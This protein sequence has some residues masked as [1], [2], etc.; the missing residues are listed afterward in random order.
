MKIYL[1]SFYRL[2]ISGLGPNFKIQG[3]TEA[4]YLN[5]RDRP[6]ELKA[7]SDLDR[8]MPSAQTLGGLGRSKNRA[9]QAG[10]TEVRLDWHISDQISNNRFF[11]TALTVA[12]PP[13]R[14]LV[15]G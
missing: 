2:Q 14:Y 7:I 1:R 11:S 3:P 4:R 10:R 8:P 15:S 12:G 5:L 9:V 13:E 6:P